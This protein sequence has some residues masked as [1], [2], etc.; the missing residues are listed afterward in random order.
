MKL[1]KKDIKH[2]A[3][4]ARLELSEDEIKK[5]GDQLSDVLGLF[6]KLNEVDTTNVEPT[7]QV[8]GLTNKLREDVVNEWDDDEKRAALDEAPD[9]ENK[10]Y[11]VKRILG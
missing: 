9:F 4:L 10:Q 2:I 1:E 3:N 7:A 5:Y 6:D 11:K 8:T